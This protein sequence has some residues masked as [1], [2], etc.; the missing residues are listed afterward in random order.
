VQDTWYGDRRDIVKWGT[1]AHLVKREALKLI[2]QVP[3]LRIG[4][5]SQLTTPTGTTEIDVSVWKHFRTVTSVQQ[6][7]PAI[8]CEILVIAD[9]FD[10]RRRQ[11]YSTTLEYQ[12][13]KLSVRKAVLLD[14]DTGLSAKPKPEHVSIAE[15]QSAWKA[16]RAGDYL[17]LY[18]HAWRNKRW[19]SEAQQRFSLAC[20]ATNTEIFSAPR[21]ASDVVFLA[22][23]KN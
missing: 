19:K 16:L 2:V 13:T 15:V 8:G 17:V 6:L 21:I 5:R 14:P 18:Q 20:G 22:A 1:L 4:A 12:L 10:P 11:D 9:E 3:Y 7:G 23:Q